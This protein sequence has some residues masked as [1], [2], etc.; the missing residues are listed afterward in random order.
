MPPFQIRLPR[1]QKGGSHA[2]L[3]IRYLVLIQQMVSIQRIHSLLRHTLLLAQVLIPK[4]SQNRTQLDL[5]LHRCYA[6]IFFICSVIFFQ[7]DLHQHSQKHVFWQG[8]QIFTST[9]IS[10]ISKRV[11]MI[12]Y[13]PTSSVFDSQ[14]PPSNDRQ[15]VCCI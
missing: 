1:M 6:T 13:P 14:K 15:C 12:P 3:G 10:K 9:T 7:L 2:L 11:F 8:L 4:I 5:H